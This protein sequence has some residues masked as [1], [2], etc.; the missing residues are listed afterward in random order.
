MSDETA[1]DAWLAEGHN[2]NR[3]WLITPLKAAFFQVT[4]SKGPSLLEWVGITSSA[5]F[6]AA[7][8][9]AIYISEK[10]TGA[11]ALVVVF[12]MWIIKA[13]QRLG[14]KSAVFKTPAEYFETEKLIERIS[15]LMDQNHWPDERELQ[16]E[17]EARST[18]I[19]AVLS[20]ME[21]A[22]RQ[23]VNGRTGQVT[24]TFAR[25]CEDGKY[26]DISHRNRGSE[27]AH[28]KVPAADFILAHRV[29][30]SKPQERI[31][32]DLL[33]FPTKYHSSPTRGKTDYRSF[34]IIPVFSDLPENDTVIGFVSIDC[35][36]PY[37]FH[38]NRATFI[39][40]AIAPLAARIPARLR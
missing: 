37:A 1:V 18:Y 27:R 15:E 19:T 32:H 7:P 33:A 2:P 30:Q 5:A 40:A 20:I 36:I 38:G 25:Y 9:F 29:C 13:I 3:R 6:I 31:V 8:T 17:A 10:I 39:S 22:V 4:R 21:V 26:I 35:E 12:S 23:L 34:Y 24:V 14:S 28:R 16:A 11:Q